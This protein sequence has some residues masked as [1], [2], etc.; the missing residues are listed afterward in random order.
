MRQALLYHAN[1]LALFAGCGETVTN[2]APD[3]ASQ[4]GLSSESTAGSDAISAGGSNATGGSDMASQGGAASGSAAGGEASGD[5]CQDLQLQAQQAADLSCQVDSDCIHPPHSE[6][7]CTEC[8]VELNAA[9]EQTS[10]IAVRA[11]CQR[12]YAQGC[13]TARH[14]CLAQKPA[15]NAGVCDLSLP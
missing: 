14:S 11:V 12:F 13:E 6:G 9:T 2:G 3:T 7:D 15:C 10:M 1:A 4:G 8:G 5:S